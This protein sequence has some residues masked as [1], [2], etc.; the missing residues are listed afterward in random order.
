MWKKA[1]KEPLHGCGFYLKPA[2]AMKRALLVYP[3]SRREG[4]INNDAGRTFALNVY[5]VPA[6]MKVKAMPDVS[7]VHATHPNAV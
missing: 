7:P 3:E 4:S 6:R 1:A 2:L 5:P